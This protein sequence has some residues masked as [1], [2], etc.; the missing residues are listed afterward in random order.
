MLVKGNG[1][2][3]ATDKAQSNGTRQQV[4]ETTK[5]KVIQRQPPYK[6][7]YS[8]MCD[9]PPRILADGQ[10]ITLKD[11]M[12]LSGKTI[13]GVITAAGAV[14]YEIDFSRR[15]FKDVK[16]DDI[17]FVNTTFRGA[18]FE[19][20]WVLIVGKNID[21]TD[22]N[23][24][25]KI[26]PWETY[27]RNGTTKKIY[28]G[29]EPWRANCLIIDG[30]TENLFSQTIPY[31]LKCINRVSLGFTRLSVEAARG[32]FSGFEFID[33]HIPNVEGSIP[34]KNVACF[35]DAYFRG[36]GNLG[37]LTQEQLI[38]TKNYQEGVFEG[39]QYC[40]LWDEK[41]PPSF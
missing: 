32:D 2:I 13:E 29:G 30:T 6:Y 11:G 24:V 20:G 4:I 25:P 16:I 36:W 3:L 40:M 19:G 39:S 31:K 33:A 41:P 27:E 5:S 17:A 14:F 37:R 7:P 23:M 28:D 12:D 22:V 8:L 9:D 15:L 38:S 34:S 26:W 1:L 21:F 35:R 18:V 10:E